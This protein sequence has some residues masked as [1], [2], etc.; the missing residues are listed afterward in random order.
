MSKI[1][2]YFDENLTVEIAE[3]LKRHG[4]DVVTVRDVGKFGD[5]DKNHLERATK[6]G[7]VLCTQDTDF[8][9]LNAEGFSHSGIAFGKQY[10]SGISGWVKALR[11]L[12]DTKS[13][14]EVIGQVEFLSVK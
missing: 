11:K 5:D 10:L 12:H 6:M 1:T 14:E 4:I 13:A 2:F 3:Q 9:R 8:L 7:R